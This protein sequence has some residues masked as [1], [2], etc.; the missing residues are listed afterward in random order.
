MSADDVLCIGCKFDY[1]KTI[2]KFY[3]DNEASVE[4]LRSHGVLPLGVK[5]KKCHRPCSFR[6]DTRSW[7]CRRQFLDH[8]DGRKKCCN[9][10]VSDCAGTLL[11]KSK[12]QPWKCLLFVNHWLSR[13]WDHECIN[14]CLQFS[15]S[16]SVF[17]RSYCSD[18]LE[19][20]FHRQNPI[21]GVGVVVEI[22]MTSIQQTWLL[23]G[24]E[25]ASKKSFVVS[26]RNQEV[27]EDLLVPLIKKHVLPGSVICTEYIMEYASLSSHEYVLAT[28]NASSI[29]SKCC[30]LTVESMWCDVKKSLM[31]SGMRE[32]YLEQYLAKYLFVCH[33][34]NSK[35]VLHHFFTE[36]GQIYPPKANHANVNMSISY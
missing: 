8:L 21:G 20:W 19:D 1:L 12:I 29:D 4:F 31:R 25:R 11:E 34:E 30:T 2:G 23:G 17:W 24:I 13:N 10:E 26:L 16:T 14:E 33:H 36:V 32:K 18:V 27:N 9:Y 5:C 22:G 3:G 28:T 35:Q 15:R 6:S 7:R